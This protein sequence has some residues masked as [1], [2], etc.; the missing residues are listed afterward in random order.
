MAINLE[1]RY[2]GQTNAGVDGYP[3]GA[4]KNVNTVGDG[5]GTPW[6]QAI[7]NDIFGFLQ[8]L[9]VSAGITPSDTPDNA[10]VS[11]YRE[12]IQALTR[13]PSIRLSVAGTSVQGG[14]TFT[15]A[16]DFASHAGFYSI[17]PGVPA[18]L[19]VPPGHYMV[20]M[21]IRAQSSVSTD[22]QDIRIAVGN[23]TMGFMDAGCVRYNTNPV[24]PMY[25]TASQ[26][27]R[28]TVSPNDG[29]F[30]SPLAAGG[31]SVTILSGKLS[32]V[33]LGDLNGW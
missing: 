18:M 32:V 17:V 20:S 31:G 29:I 19:W 10:N 33:R 22:N 15:L 12:A 7:P 6:E 16:E 8:G 2:P 24:R 28:N 21:N 4:A 13:R 3:Y 5:T 9:L 25:F 27:M 1:D 23:G 26:I 30:V 14:G 11:Q